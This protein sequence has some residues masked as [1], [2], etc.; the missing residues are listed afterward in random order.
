MSLGGLV[1]SFLQEERRPRI[2][3]KRFY[4]LFTAILV[5]AGAIRLYRLD[6]FSYGLDEILQAYWIQG[7][8]AFFWKSL[9]FDAVHPPLDYLIARGV[10]FL[11][12]ADWARKLPDA[13]WGLGTIAALGTL[14]ARR[15]TRAAALMTALFL[16]FSPFH[17]RYS[18]E[19]R[20][21]SLGLFALCLSLLCL[22]RFLERPG[23]L[24]LAALYAA[25]LATAYTL[26]L[27][28]I[29][30][31][32]A[33]GAML[34][35]DSFSLDLARRRAARRFLAWSPLFA[36]LLFLAYLPWWPVVLEAGRRPPA[37]PAEPLSW[38]RLGRTFSFFA[39]A[40]DD[41]DPFRWMTALWVAL[42]IAGIILAY[43]TRG[44]R[45][46]LVWCLGGALAI[47]IL[48]HL[49]PHW[50]VTR[51]FLPAG[52]A[53]PVLVALPFARIQTRQVR[54]LGAVAV[55]ALLVFDAG[56][57]NAYFRE[58]RAD[59]RPLGN[60]LKA[61]PRQERVFT[62]NQYSQLCVAFYVEGPE[63]L[64]RGGHLGRDIWNLEGEIIRLTWSW[65]PG[66]TAWL[67]LAGQ[68]EQPALREWAKPLQM[69][70]YPTAEGALLVRLD[71]ASRDRVLPRQH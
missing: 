49:H 27:A 5:L 12:P 53:L 22:D 41:G 31:A 1:R 8:W 34:A 60:F 33:A 13:L 58:G 69:T 57:L 6:H 35:E 62:E 37:V 14:V 47:E 7:D 43:R 66:T 10:E 64:Y 30:L 51:R 36:A 32:L 45:F 40:H 59:W 48:G 70:G 56:G 15:A 44:L 23:F 28:A 24:R 42:L 68:P 46:F 50:Y 16:A 3:N 21:Y 20:P 67:V 17:V 61:R 9:N 54:A 11:A 2:E 55:A 39:F 52:V 38:S 29:V 65:K 19:F 18:Q 26:Y 4:A 25:C 63:W 71:P